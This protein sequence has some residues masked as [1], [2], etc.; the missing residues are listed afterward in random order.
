MILNDGQSR[1][2]EDAI[3]WY[4]DPNSSQVFEID[5]LAGTGKSVLIYHILKELHLSSD[6]YM[7]MAYTGQASIVMRT[8]GFKTAKSIHSSLYEIIEYYDQSDINE[9]FGKPK[10]RFKFRLRRIIDPDVRLFFIDEGYMVPDTMVRD[11]LSFGIKVI[12]CGDTHQLPPV[13]Y[14][15]A[16]FTGRWETHHLTQLM[17]QS[18]DD[19][20]IYLANKIIHDQPIHNGSYGSVMVIDDVDFIPQMLGYADVILSGTNRT[21]DIMN[22]YVRNIAGFKTKTPCYGERLICRNNDWDMQVDGI[23]LANGL[24]GT[25]TSIPDMVNF[26]GKT[27]DINFRPDILPNSIFYDVPVNFKY[28]TASFDEKQ[29]MRDYSFRRYMQ[30]QMFEFAY[31]ITTHL[32]QGGEFNQGIIIKEHLHPQMQK[33]LDYTAITRFKKSCIIVNKTD[34]DVRVPNINAI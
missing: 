21:R 4:R 28:F 20:I 27:F 13:G 12:V 8:K 23:A 24:I 25:V 14:K 19:P 31:C 2:L 29:Q 17:R 34:R 33:Q 5:G 16:F 1:I 26:K 18:L 30:G 3:E 15:P 9:I 7:P 10:K 22:S 6:Q 11:I 32:S